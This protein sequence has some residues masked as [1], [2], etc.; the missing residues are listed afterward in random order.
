MYKG[1]MISAT[2]IRQALA[3]GDIQTANDMLGRKFS[4][5]F[6]FFAQPR[7]NSATPKS[8]SL[9]DGFYSAD[10]I[11]FPLPALLYYDS[12]C[13]SCVPTLIKRVNHV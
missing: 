10:G 3:N 7:A 6:A 8:F 5:D 11:L 9:A 12:H 13:C 2:R 4:Y 1:E